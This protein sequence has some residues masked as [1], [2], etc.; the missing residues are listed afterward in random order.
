MSSGADWR[1]YD[2]K[3]A[4]GS[5]TFSLQR[6][7]EL[8]GTFDLPLLGA[9]NVR[10]AL[11]A[12]AVALELGVEFETAARALAKFGGISRRFEIKGA[13]PKAH[14]LRPE[15]RLRELRKSHVLEGKRYRNFQKD[16]RRLIDHLPI[17][18]VAAN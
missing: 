3:V 17:R 13:I 7:G 9:F 4:E 11:A 2:L 14:P 1:A 5:T 6:K 8:T 18:R 16:S 12:I 10:N 15:G